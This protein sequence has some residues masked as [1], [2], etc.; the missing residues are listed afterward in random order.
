MEE[1]SVEGGN[2]IQD[3]LQI[4]TSGII[5]GSGQLPC[6]RFLLLSSGISLLVC[7]LIAVICIFQ[8]VFFT[9]PDI[10][11][12]DCTFVSPPLHVYL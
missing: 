8:T 11:R 12:K 9:F 5:L 3:F 7:F 1:G 10:C 6:H 2:Q 4:Q